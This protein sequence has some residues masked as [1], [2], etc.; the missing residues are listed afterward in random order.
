MP[1]ISLH[2]QNLTKAFS[3]RNIFAKINFSIQQSQTLA[4]TGRNGSGKS[5]LIKIL[6]GVL[7]ATSGSVKLS[8]DGEDVANEDMYRHIGLVSPYLQLYDEF[9]AAENLTFFRELRR[10]KNADIDGLLQRVGLF[11]RRNDAVR[12]YSSGMKQR[13]KY[14]FALLHQPPILF[15]DEP[16]ANLDTEGI[17]FVYDIIDEYKKGSIVIVASNVREETELCS[18]IINLNDH[19]L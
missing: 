14:V 19:V 2:A 1:T 11:A 15:L 7:S 5:T 4:I 16:T 6:A 17:R 8:Y 18:E 3:H 12:T 10:I 13:L 9:T